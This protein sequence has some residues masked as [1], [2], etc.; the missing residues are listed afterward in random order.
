M[1]EERT[2]AV[3]TNYW[4]S[5]LGCSVTDLSGKAPIVIAH[6]SELAGY[7]GLIAF[8]REAAP[9]ISVPADLRQSA[10][11]YVATLSPHDFGSP[12]NFAACLQSLPG[13]VIGPAFVGYAD[14]ST[15]RRADGAAQGG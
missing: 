4:T 2:I 15:L 13:T 12:T 5:H 10:S 1:L 9:G 11:A 3:V 14:H 8:F 6:S 7:R